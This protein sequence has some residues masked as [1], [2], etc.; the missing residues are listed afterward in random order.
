[1]DLPYWQGTAV[2]I[3]ISM[4]INE[5]FQDLLEMIRHAY[6]LDVKRARK[7]KY[8]KAKFI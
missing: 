1:M 8:R 4:D 3:D 6:H 7:N 2:G 5:D